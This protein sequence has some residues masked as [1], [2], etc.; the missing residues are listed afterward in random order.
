MK[1]NKKFAQFSQSLGAPD[2][3]GLSQWTQHQ[4]VYGT[5]GVN[6]VRE[7]KRRPVMIKV[8]SLEMP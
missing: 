4:A 8:E 6:Y 5:R 7:H 2:D 3:V 1:G